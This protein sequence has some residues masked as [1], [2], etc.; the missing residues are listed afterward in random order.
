CWGGG[1]AACPSADCTPSPAGP[2][3]GSLLLCLCHRHLCNGRGPAAGGAPHGPAPTPGGTPWLWAAAP[4]LFLLLFLTCLA[5][6]GLRR[7]RAPPARPPRR[8]QR[9]RVPPDPPSP[10]LPALRFLQVLQA[11]RFSAVW[12]GTL[13][14]QPVAIK[15]FAAGGAERFAAERAVLRL[16]LMEHRNVAKLLRAARAGGPRARGGVLVLQLY[17]AGSLRHFLAQHVGTWAGSVRLALSLARGLAFLHQ[18]LWR[19]GLYKPSVAHRD[20]SS[21]N[22]LVREDGTCAIGDFGLALALPPGGQDGSAARRGGVHIRRAGTQRYLAPEI[23]DESLDLRAWGR[24]LRQADVYALA[25]LLWE[26]LSRCQALSPGAP[27]PP[28]QLA[29]EAELGASPTDAQLRHL[30]VEERRRPLIPPAWHHVPQP[31]GALPELLEDCWDPDPEAR[32]SAERA[33]Q[34]LQRLAA[35]PPPPNSPLLTSA[36]PP[37]GS[38]QRG[39]PPAAAEREVGAEGTRERERERRAAGPRRLPSCRPR[40]R[41]EP[42][43][44]ALPIGWRDARMSRPRGGVG[45]PLSTSEAVTTDGHLHPAM[46][47]CDQPGQP[48]DHRLSPPQKGIA[49]QAAPAEARAAK[50]RRASSPPGLAEQQRGRSRDSSSRHAPGQAARHTGSDVTGRPASGVQTTWPTGS[51]VSGTAA[52]GMPRANN[53]ADRKTD[54][55]ARMGRSGASKPPAELGRPPASGFAASQ[56]PSSARKEPPPGRLQRRLRRSPLG[57]GAVSSFPPELEDVRRAEFPFEPQISEILLIER[58][59]SNRH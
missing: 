15:A 39:G 2:P 12:Q 57:S 30:A 17:P 25:L 50:P 59:C 8:W 58:P 38:G 37:G 48:T 36:A 11:G 34:R 20:L 47:M 6:L 35:G 54:G 14:R 32:L 49:R 41:E 40:P 19:D 24:A 16:P 53:M 29:Y 33:L 46:T 23:L 5:A 4:L 44:L 21:Q 42:G 1:G 3:G 7:G 51:D 45:P 55:G 9:V 28:F 27:V 26:I 22:V 56:Q 13:R 10:E 43:G 52:F 31:A 18:E